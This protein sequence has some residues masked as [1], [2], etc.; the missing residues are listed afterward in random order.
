MLAILDTIIRISKNIFKKYNVVLF[1]HISQQDWSLV[2]IFDIHRA[3]HPNIISIVKPTRCT[4]VSNLFSFGMT[5]YMFWTVFPSI[6]R[7][8]RL[9]MQQQAFVKLC[10]VHETAIY[11]CDDTRGCV[12]HFWPPDDEHIVLETCRGMK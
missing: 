12:M 9:Y 2:S 6:I 5:F 3:V 10:L 1:F 4:N 8:S 11:G 7:S